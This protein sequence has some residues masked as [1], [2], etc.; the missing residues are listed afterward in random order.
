[1][2]QGRFTT[3]ISMIKWIWTSR[4]SVNN[5]LSPRVYGTAGRAMP[6]GRIELSCES[7]LGTNKAV[8]ASPPRALPT[9]TKVESEKSQ[10]K[11]GTSADLSNSGE[12]RVNTKAVLEFT[13]CTSVLDL[14]L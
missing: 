3:I 4:L 6:R 13:S 9:E 8:R 2:A 11:S 12:Q 1:M 14:L 10:S 7:E 5:S